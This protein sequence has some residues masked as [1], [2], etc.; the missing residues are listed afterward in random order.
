MAIEQHLEALT[1]AV[2][3]IGAEHMAM[4]MALRAALGLIS[5]PRNARLSAMT[6]AHDALADELKT[7]GSDA[8]FRQVALAEFESLTALMLSETLDILRDRPTDPLPDGG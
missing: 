6:I 4:R 3:A 7:A 8:E 5:A 2:R 1:D